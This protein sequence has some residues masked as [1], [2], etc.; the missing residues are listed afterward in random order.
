M[1]AAWFSPSMAHWFVY[2]S[3]FSLFSVLGHYTRQG[4]LR[5]T[6]TGA[7]AVGAAIGV[8]LLAAMVMSAIEG[9][10]RYVLVVLGI[11]GIVMS[12]VFLVTLVWLPREY[13]RAE[14]RRMAAK[15]I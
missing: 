12:V 6:V 10:P 1:T 2:F 7:M 15:E 4:R 3:L 5:R 11:P 8:V 14:L 9:Q 13:A